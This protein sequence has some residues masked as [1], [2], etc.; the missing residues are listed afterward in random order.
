M[1]ESSELYRG[2]SMETGE[3]VQGYLYRIWEQAYI[4]W[5]AVN[6]VPDMK[7]I[8][9]ESVC[10]CT[11]KT[12]QN[13]SSIFEKDICKIHSASIDEEDGLFVV[14]WNSD[15]AKFELFGWGLLVDF[16]SYNGYE[17]ETVGN[18]YDNPEMMKGE[19]YGMHDM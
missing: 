5:G 2:K 15:S 16:E 6:G 11:G 8:D 7:E 1:T 18:I 10:K 9:P 3:W 4:L 13:G 14:E 17:C 12:D 19:A